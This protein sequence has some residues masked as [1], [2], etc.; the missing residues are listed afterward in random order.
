MMLLHQNNWRCIR[1]KVWRWQEIDKKIEK[2]YKLMG[3]CETAPYKNNVMKGMYG[4]F[5]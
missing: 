3:C 5:L 4:G 2:I 1:R